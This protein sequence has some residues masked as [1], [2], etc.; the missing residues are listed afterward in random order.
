MNRIIILIIFSIFLYSC[1]K[2]FSCKKDATTRRT[3]FSI[4]GIDV[5]HY[6]SN[7][8]WKKISIQSIDFVFIKI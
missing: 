7:I 1:I 5:S 4:E 2:T 3:D 8:D 6:Q